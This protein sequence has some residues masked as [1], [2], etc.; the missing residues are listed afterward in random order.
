MPQSSSAPWTVAWTSAPRQAIPAAAAASRSRPNVASTA[1]GEATSNATRPAEAL[2][3]TPGAS[4]FITTGKPSRS[5]T[6]TASSAVA[7]S[8]P[9]TRGMP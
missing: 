9:A 1:S 5:A 8:W 2:W 4:A 7:A 3:A 6:A